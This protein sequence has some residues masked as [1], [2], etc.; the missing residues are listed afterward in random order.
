[1][2]N[3]K[4]ND[5]SKASIRKDL[6]YYEDFQAKDYIQDR[7]ISKIKLYFKYSR[8]TERAYR[9]ILFFTLCFGALVPVLMNWDYLKNYAVGESNMGILF[10]TI[11]SIVVIILVS[12][13]ATFK[14]R[15]RLQNYKKTEDQ[16]T[17]ELYLFQSGSRPYNLDG[18]NSDKANFRLLVTRV[19]SIIEQEREDTIE[20]ATAEAIERNKLE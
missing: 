16:L 18:S 19:E 1:M 3:A 20:K 10:S 9:A 6:K 17:R 4:R 14:Y 13:E 12:L 5:V 7:L 8:R 11:C 15:E 2:T